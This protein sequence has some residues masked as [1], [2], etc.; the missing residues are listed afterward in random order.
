M[1]LLVVCATP[2]GRSGTRRRF[3]VSKQRIPHEPAWNCSEGAGAMR[4][5]RACLYRPTFLYCCSMCRWTPGFGMLQETAEGSGRSWASGRAHD[6]P[7]GFTVGASLSSLATTARPPKTAPVKE[8]AA[9]GALKEHVEGLRAWH[10][11]WA[12]TKYA[13]PDKRAR[14]VAAPRPGQDCRVVRGEVWSC[15]AATRSKVRW[16]CTPSTA[17]V[18]EGFTARLWPAQDD[19][20]LTLRAGVQPGAVAKVKSVRP[21]KRHP[22]RH[23]GSATARG[24][25]HAHAR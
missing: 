24:P 3:G 20:R 16:K 1:R 4:S 7:Y 18:S 13:G 22:G 15:H 9:G 2:P 10:V 17:S 5:L 25:D 19:L 6:G 11:S 14:G 23:H 8:G 12:C 21:V